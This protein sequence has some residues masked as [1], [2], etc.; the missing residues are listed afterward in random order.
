MLH[1]RF[2]DKGETLYGFSKPKVKSVETQ[3]QSTRVIPKSPLPSHK[4]RIEFDMWLRHNKQHIEKTTQFII[5]GLQSFLAEN[6]QYICS[7]NQ[8]KFEKDLQVMLYKASHNSF[9][10]YLLCPNYTS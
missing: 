2:N 3:L 8:D 7:L 1:L 5:E 4:K 9:K 10:N 6:P